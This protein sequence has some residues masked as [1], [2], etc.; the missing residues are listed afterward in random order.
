MI[1]LINSGTFTPNNPLLGSIVDLYQSQIVKTAW[2]VFGQREVQ[3][4][5]RGWLTG[6]FPN[7]TLLSTLSILHQSI[8]TSR[9]AHHLS[10]GNPFLIRFN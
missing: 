6:P 3:A 9:L 1:N 10:G 8:R 7:R 5:G 4:D 2:S